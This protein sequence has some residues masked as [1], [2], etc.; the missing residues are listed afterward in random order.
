MLGETFACLSMDQE[1]F[2]K[3]KQALWHPKVKIPNP[4]LLEEPTV[5]KYNE[6]DLMAYQGD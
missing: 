5:P 4:C 3:I 1:Y 6:V 2:L